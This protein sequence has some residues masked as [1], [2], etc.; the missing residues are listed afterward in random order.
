M[1]TAL[2]VTMV[3]VLCFSRSYRHSHVSCACFAWYHCT[4][5]AAQCTLL[6]QEL[7]QAGRVDTIYTER[8]AV[9]HSDDTNRYGERIP[10][11]FRWNIALTGILTRMSEPLIIHA[12]CS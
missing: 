8:S 3:C 11:H 5:G 1:L 10:D 4:T 2:V 7:E 12:K 6:L 9:S